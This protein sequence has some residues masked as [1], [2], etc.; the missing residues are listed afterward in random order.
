MATAK[1]PTAKRKVSNRRRG[2]T[3]KISNRTDHLTV[4]Q[5]QRAVDIVSRGKK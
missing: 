4:A 1:Q 2:R 3:I 5:V